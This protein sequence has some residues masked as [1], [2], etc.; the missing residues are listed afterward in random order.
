ME[1][2]VTVYRI[3]LYGDNMGQETWWLHQFIDNLKSSGVYTEEWM[4]ERITTHKYVFIIK[5]RLYT[6]FV[7]KEDSV[8]SDSEDDLSWLND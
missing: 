5:T 1:E 7:T 4:L 8:V 2:T 3:H 6:P